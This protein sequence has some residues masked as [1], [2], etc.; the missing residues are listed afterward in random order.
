VV[1]VAGGDAP[2]LGVTQEMHGF[3][4]HPDGRRIVFGPRTK[5]NEEVW[6]LENLLPPAKAVAA[7]AK[8]EGSHHR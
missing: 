8:P 4:I 2:P 1:A 3:S 7:A 6:L 5:P